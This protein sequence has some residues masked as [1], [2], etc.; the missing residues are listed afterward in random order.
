MSRKAEAF[1]LSVMLVMFL[2]V[3]LGCSWAVGSWVP[4]LGCL[5]A[6]GIAAIIILAVIGLCVLAEKL[7]PRD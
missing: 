7:F 4:F 1:V 6:L 3:G 5:L 2:V